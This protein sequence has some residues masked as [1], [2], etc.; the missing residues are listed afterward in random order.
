MSTDFGTRGLRL[1]N[2]G[3]FRGSKQTGFKGKWCPGFEIEKE[4][5]AIC[6]VSATEGV[7]FQF[8]MYDLRIGVHTCAGNVC[9]MVNNFATSIVYQGW[10]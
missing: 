1:E 9:R 7:I 3:Q 6:F 4:I 2:S 10:S 8:V 5:F